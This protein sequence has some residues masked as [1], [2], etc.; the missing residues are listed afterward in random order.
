MGR[1]GHFRLA[2][3]PSTMLAMSERTHQPANMETLSNVNF[4]PILSLSST[5]SLNQNQLISTKTSTPV[6][7]RV[8]SF[9]SQ[10]DAL[11]FSNLLGLNKSNFDHDLQPNIS[12]DG[13]LQ[14]A[15]CCYDSKGK[16]ISKHYF[17]HIHI[18]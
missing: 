13:N 10:I 9:V 2:L 8:F 16:V 6:P 4:S 1:G 15:Q 17:V 7:R 14:V 5:I 3:R 18:R 11:I 12:S